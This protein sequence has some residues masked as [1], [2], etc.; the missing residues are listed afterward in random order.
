MRLK[1]GDVFVFARGGEEARAL[2]E[3]SV[4]FEIVR[5]YVGDRRTRLRRDPVTHRAHNTSFTIATGH[6]DPEGLI[7]AGLRQAANRQA[8][9]IFLGDG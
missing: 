5:D 4:P 2:A 8:T 6:E 9:T 3:A 1:G 7:I